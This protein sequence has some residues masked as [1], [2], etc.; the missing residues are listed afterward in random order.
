MRERLGLHGRQ[1]HRRVNPFYHRGAQGQPL[2]MLAR[3][4]DQPFEILVEPLP[5]T[6]RLRPLRQIILQDQNG[7][8]HQFPVPPDPRPDVLKYL[9]Q[10]DGLQHARLAAFFG[11]AAQIKP[12]RDFLAGVFGK[13]QIFYFLKDE[14][15]VVPGVTFESTLGVPYVRA[16][17]KVAFHYFL[18]QFP[19]YSG[20]DPAFDRL[21]IFIARGG[22]PREVVVVPSRPFVLSQIERRDFSSWGHYLGA[23]VVISELI[24]VKVQLFAG[25]DH[26]TP[27]WEFQLG[28]NPSSVHPDRTTG[29]ALLYYGCV[30]DGHDGYV[31]PL[32]GIRRV[33]HG[34]AL[35][36]IRSAPGEAR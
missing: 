12:M 11:E 8:Y 31:Q 34:N 29:H 1:E 4:P 19:H 14:C 25:P 33:S 2:R 5:G 21:R 22:D 9:V 32:V 3:L 6:D 28:R 30:K 15:L 18:R 7:G 24:T 36:L 35:E 27:V 16:L 10:R 26:L 23:R 17:A 13:I 20:R